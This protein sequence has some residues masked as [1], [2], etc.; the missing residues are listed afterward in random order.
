[1]AMNQ[2]SKAWPLC[3]LFNRPTADHI[4]RHQIAR[5]TPNVSCCRCRQ[6]QHIIAPH[7]SLDAG[8]IELIGRGIDF[9]RSRNTG[10]TDVDTVPRQS[11]VG[12]IKA[13]H[14]LTEG[15]RRRADASGQVDAKVGERG[16]WRFK[17]SQPFIDRINDECIA[18]NVNDTGTA[19]ARSKR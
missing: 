2:R 6:R 19:R 5:S 13:S 9:E 16:R 18:R 4:G 15:D 1:M 10:E 3:D 7:R 11:Q 14:F 12:Q 17:I 8:Q